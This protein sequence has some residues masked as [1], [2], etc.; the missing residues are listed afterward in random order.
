M[1]RRLSRREF[2]H[3]LSLGA[4]PLRTFFKVTLPKIKWALMYGV[5]L[6]SFP[7]GI[8]QPGAGRAR[9]GWTAR[10]EKADQPCSRC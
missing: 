6:A 10:Q 4:G 2:L 9:R 8:W 5:V 1:P 3:S 7:A